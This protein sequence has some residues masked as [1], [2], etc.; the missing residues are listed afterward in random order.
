MVEIL[1][2]HLHIQPPLASRV[3]CPRLLSTRSLPP[4]HLTLRP[5]HLRYR[6]QLRLV[7]VDYHL[8]S[9]VVKRPRQIGVDVHGIPVP[10]RMA[11]ISDQSLTDSVSVKPPTLLAL[12]SAH[13]SWSHRRTSPATA[14]RLS[15]TILQSFS[16]S[17]SSSNVFQASKRSIK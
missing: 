11:V 3:P 16:R 8:L 2:L 6:V 5:I 4:T 15:T 13:L 7:L 1:L 17:Y 10:T 9:D 12:Y 14:A